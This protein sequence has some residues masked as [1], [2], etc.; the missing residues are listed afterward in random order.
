MKRIFKYTAAL[1]GLAV[2]ISIGVEI[3]TLSGL[4]YEH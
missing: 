4:P 3:P 1:V 2:L